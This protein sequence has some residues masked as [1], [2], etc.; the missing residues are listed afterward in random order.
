MCNSVQARA[1]EKLTKLGYVADGNTEAQKRSYVPKATEVTTD[2]S[3]REIIR[4]S[5]IPMSLPLNLH[6][7][8]K[9]DS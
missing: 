7:P 2:A 1:F 5:L 6:D 4:L 8:S 9:V 3:K